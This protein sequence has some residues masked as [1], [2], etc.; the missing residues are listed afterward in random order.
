MLREQGIEPSA[1]T[2]HSVGEIAA[3]WASGAL[4]LQQAIHVICVRSQ[5]Q[6]LTRGK[7]RMAAVGLSVEAIQEIIT[8]LGVDAEVEIAGI[9]SPGNVTLSGPLEDLQQIQ[10]VA[11]SG[12]FLPAARSRLCFP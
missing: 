7:G 6:G 12:H 4:D 5:A 1:V 9:N 2:G 3:A 8:T 10:S 11:E